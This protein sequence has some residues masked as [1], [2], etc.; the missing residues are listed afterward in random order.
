MH[1]SHEIFLSLLFSPLT[2]SVGV[3]EAKKT[4]CTCSHRL[5]ERRKEEREKEIV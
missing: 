5:R 2:E 1:C 3:D 4:G